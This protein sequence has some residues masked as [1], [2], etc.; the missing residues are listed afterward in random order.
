[1]GVDTDGN[2]V[3][4][5]VIFR[6]S[7]NN[8]LVD[9][10]S[11][12]QSDIGITSLTSIPYVPEVYGADKV[13]FV[14][15]NYAAIREVY[16]P[17]PIAVFSSL[18]DYI[19]IDYH[20]KLDMGDVRTGKLKIQVNNN[21][22]TLSITDDYSYSSPLGRAMGIIVATVDNNNRPIGNLEITDV[23]FG[24]LYEGSVLTGLNIDQGTKVTVVP[25]AGLID[26]ITQAS[27]YYKVDR[28]PVFSPTSNEPA[29][30]TF[31]RDTAINIVFDAIIVNNDDSSDL[32]TIVL[33]YKQLY[34]QPPEAPIQNGRSSAGI[35][36]FDVSYGTLRV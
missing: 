17:E 36:S 26:P 27:I 35:I 9:C 29:P 3:V 5:A 14:T 2:Y 16:S 34:G 31:T 25:G 30:I 8:L 32:E 22:Q 1:M 13:T 12:R 10:S 4:P 11:D 21:A 24:R 6:Q 18:N 15:R 20:I 19:E 7:Q 33:R 28:P 23:E